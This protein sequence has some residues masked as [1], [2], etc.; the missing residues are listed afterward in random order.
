MNQKAPG[1]SD[2]DAFTS[3]ST[4]AESSAT[5]PESVPPVVQEVSTPEVVQPDPEVGNHVES[6]NHVTRSDATSPVLPDE[7]AKTSN[8]SESA[9]TSKSSSQIKLKYEYSESK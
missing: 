2:L 1:G 8:R 9:P 3:N 7:D 4:S 6:S 5:T